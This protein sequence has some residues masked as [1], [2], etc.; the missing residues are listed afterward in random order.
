MWNIGLKV[1]AHKK[2]SLLITKLWKIAPNNKLLSQIL[3]FYKESPQ[4]TVV[5]PKS[6]ESFVSIY[7]VQNNS[8]KIKESNY[9]E[10]V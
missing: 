1:A 2:R 8:N 7:L 10:K 5:T 4:F 3:E 9:T 6:F